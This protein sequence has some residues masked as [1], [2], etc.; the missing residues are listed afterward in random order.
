MSVIAKVT[1]SRR[2]MDVSGKLGKRSCVVTERLARGTYVIVKH[3]YYFLVCWV[4]DSSISND[5]RGILGCCFV[6]RLLVAEF[7]FPL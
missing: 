1:D 5:L 3:S 2:Q 4:Y 6:L 7:F